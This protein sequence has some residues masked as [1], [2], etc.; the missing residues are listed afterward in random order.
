ML[1]RIDN[2]K[3]FEREEMIQEWVGIGRQIVEEP[4]SALKGMALKRNSWCQLAE[5][6]LPKSKLPEIN[7]VYIKFTWIS[8]IFFN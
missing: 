7:S 6:Q 8:T 4:E 1:K 5:L 3:G 2:C